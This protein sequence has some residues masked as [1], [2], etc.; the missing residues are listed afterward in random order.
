MAR[1]LLAC[2]DSEGKNRDEHSPVHS[3][4][5]T[6]TLDSR[7]HAYIHTY[8]THIHM[9]THSLLRHVYTHAHAP[10]HT[11]SP[12]TCTHAHTHHI[13]IHTLLSDKCIRAYMHTYTYTRPHT[14]THTY[15]HL[16]TH[17][18]YTLTGILLTRKHHHKQKKY[19]EAAT[20][21]PRFA[22]AFLTKR[23]VEL[24]R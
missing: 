20:C 4:T 24:F 17:H 7:T 19:E 10:T 22:C 1:R 8:L 18:I 13:P 9:H 3:C 12:Y 16:H 23:P 6:R 5:R 2:A 11:H 14:H 21:M 15:A